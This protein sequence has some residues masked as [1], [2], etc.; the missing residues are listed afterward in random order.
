SRACTIFKNYPQCY[1]L[2]NEI[3]LLDLDHD[4]EQQQERAYLFVTCPY[5]SK[6]HKVVCL[7]YQQQL[8]AREHSPIILIQSVVGVSH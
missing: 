4:K 8:V 3:G 2:Q 1:L 6:Y 5:D 7:L